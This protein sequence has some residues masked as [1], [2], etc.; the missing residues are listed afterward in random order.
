MRTGDKYTR[1]CV[2]EHCSPQYDGVCPTNPVTDARPAVGLAR[3]FRDG[4]SVRYD[5]A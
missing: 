4:G 1:Y 5:A 3:V 2:L